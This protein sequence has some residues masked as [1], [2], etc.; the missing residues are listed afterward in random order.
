MKVNSIATIEALC[1]KPYIFYC[2][3]IP[4][5]RL[6]AMPIV[7]PILSIDLALLEDDFVDGYWEGVAMFYLSMTNEGGL[8]DKVMDEDLES[9]NPL[10]CAVNDCL[11]A[12]H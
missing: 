5:C 6:V 3:P 4:M 12:L 10:W 8:V 9:W 2:M 1:L 11:Q 7:R